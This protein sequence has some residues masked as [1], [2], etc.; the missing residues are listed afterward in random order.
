MNDKPT[1]L[2]NSNSTIIKELVGKWFFFLYAVVYGCFILINVT[3]PSFMGIG[4]GDFNIAIVFG[5]GLIVFAI[6]LAFAYNHISTRAEELLDKSD[7]D[8]E[9]VKK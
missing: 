3:S 1:K 8:N 7:D 4:V 2:L 6:L 5:F 9:G